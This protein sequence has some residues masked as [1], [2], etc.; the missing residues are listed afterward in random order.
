MMLTSCDSTGRYQLGTNGTNRSYL[1][2]TV[3]GTVRE[4]TDEGLVEIRE[5]R[6]STND[7]EETRSM[8]E[9]HH[10]DK[11]Q[12]WTGRIDNPEAFGLKSSE[13]IVKTL[14]NGGKII[15]VV[16]PTDAADW[17]S[18]KTATQVGFTFYNGRGVEVASGIGPLDPFAVADFEPRLDSE[19]SKN[20]LSRGEI[21]GLSPG[22]YSS[23]KSVSMFCRRNT[24]E[25]V[26]K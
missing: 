4:I 20:V 17:S 18:A 26:G 21:T 22:D 25:A 19:H 1:V 12:C 8:D 23:I 9:K 7:L 10:F 13:L 14:W 15:W 6:I 3:N 11:W 16:L 5:K 2:D 24:M